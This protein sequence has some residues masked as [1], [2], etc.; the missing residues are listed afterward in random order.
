MRCAGTRPNEA[1]FAAEH[2]EELRQF[3][4]SHR[5]KNTSPG[6]DARITG[7][8]E[9]CHRAI[10]LYELVHVTLVTL[11]LDID[12]HSSELREYETFSPVAY[13]L[14]PKK[15]RPGRNELNPQRDEDHDRQPEGQ[16]QQNTGDVEN[17]FPRRDLSGA[18]DRVSAFFP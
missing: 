3:I 2:V 17:A 11:G 14:L 16:T 1:H 9:L 12:L 6:N 4:Q 7:G 10:R 18:G 5:P 8:V 15:N 13:A